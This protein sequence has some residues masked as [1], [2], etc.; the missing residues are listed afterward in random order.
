M[1]QRIDPQQNSV[2]QVFNL[3]FSKKRVFCHQSLNHE[4]HKD[5]DDHEDHEAHLD[6]E[7]HEDHDNHD[8]E[9][10]HAQDLESNRDSNGIST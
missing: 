4:D 3:S 2:P 1:V 9:T 8:D 6:H 7:D 10:N 5:H